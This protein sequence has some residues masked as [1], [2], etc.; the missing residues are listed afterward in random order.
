VTQPRLVRSRSRS[1][2][3][4]FKLE[5]KHECYLPTTC[6]LL[7]PFLLLTHILSLS[8]S[9]LSLPVPSLCGSKLVS[10][11]LPDLSSVAS[12]GRQSPPS[13]NVPA[14]APPQSP[15][16]CLGL[17]CLGPCSGGFFSPTS[18]LGAGGVLGHGG[19][20]IKTPSPP[21]LLPV[22]ECPSVAFSVF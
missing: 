10:L 9:D 18:R 2:N 17:Q 4:L 1:I 7:S 11:V 6:P 8:V 16:P 22:C 15:V 19:C 12:V 13:L 21:F 14:C 20:S 5:V 3:Q